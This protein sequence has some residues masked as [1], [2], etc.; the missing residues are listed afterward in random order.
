MIIEWMVKKYGLNHVGLLTLSFGV[1]GSG[2]GSQATQELRELAKD[3]G[4]VQKRWHSFNTNVVSKR[5]PDW[6]CLMEPHRDNVWHIHA[7]VVTKFDLRTGKGTRDAGAQGG[8]LVNVRLKGKPVVMLAGGVNF[9]IP[10][11]R[12]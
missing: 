12:G 7:V 1:P 8:G 4:F 2:R 5:Y 10:L 3:L 11:A 6:A 9:G